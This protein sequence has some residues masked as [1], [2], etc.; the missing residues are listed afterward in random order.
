MAIVLQIRP[1]SIGVNVGS[2]DLTVSTAV[3]I[4]VEFVMLLP[5]LI[6]ER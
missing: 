4:K 3:V 2:A 5:L 6:L 1:V